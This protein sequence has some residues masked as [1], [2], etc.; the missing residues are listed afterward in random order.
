MVKI[1]GRGIQT[2]KQHSDMLLKM[3]LKFST[4][5]LSAALQAVNNPLE[6]E[7][8]KHEQ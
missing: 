3:K 6:N 7:V 8:R 5:N 2:Q 4:K 1:K